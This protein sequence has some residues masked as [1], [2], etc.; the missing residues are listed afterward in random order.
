MGPG[1]ECET[2][3]KRDIDGDG[4]E[5]GDRDVDVENRKDGWAWSVSEGVLDMSEQEDV[6]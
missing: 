1:E 3:I 4:G 5:D 2:P 6:L